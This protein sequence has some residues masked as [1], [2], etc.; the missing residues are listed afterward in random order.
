MTKG[1]KRELMGRRRINERWKERKK[2]TKEVEERTGQL[3]PKVKKVK[4]AELENWSMDVWMKFL[5]PTFEFSEFFGS[6]GRR[7]LKGHSHEA[8]WP[9]S[10]NLGPEGPDN[11]SGWYF[12]VY[13]HVCPHKNIDQAGSQCQQNKTV[14]WFAAVFFVR[15]LYGGCWQVGLVIGA[16]WLV[17]GTCIDPSSGG[18]GS[19]TCPSGEL[20]LS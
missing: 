2:E 8:R 20:L 7:A 13:R 3:H 15:F 12:L 18:R 16:R 5:K 19:N 14:S 4:K 1:M 6:E 10:Q 11:F 9:S 17:G